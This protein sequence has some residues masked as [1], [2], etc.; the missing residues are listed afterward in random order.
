MAI[1]VILGEDN[2]LVRE[3]LRQ[4]LAGAP[5]LD[6]EAECGDGDELLREVEE[7]RPDVV[8]TD[9]RMPPTHTDEGIRLAAH[10]R[11]AHPHIGVVVLSQYAD[12]GYVL[13]LLESG[14]EGRAYLLKERVHDRR[15]LVAAIEAVASGESVID[16]K[17]VEVLVA[18]K[19]RGERS[20]LAQLTP[21]ELE[22]LAAIAEG[23]SNGAISE[24]LVLTKRAVEKHIN[25]IFL[26][27]N[28][29]QSQSAETVSPRV[30]A[31]LVFLAETSDPLG[32]GKRAP[33]R[34]RGRAPLSPSGVA[35][36]S[37]GAVCIRVL[38]VDDQAVFR[39]IAREVIDATPGFEA[40]G[41][42]AS[43]EEAL[44]A[45]ARLAPQLVL[46]DVR[47]PGL[48]G[49]EVARRLRVTHPDTVLV[50][51]SIEDWL[52]HPSAAQIAERV[53]LV[54]KQD[55]GPRHAGVDLARARSRCSIH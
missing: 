30:K 32:W 12:P 26:K 15:Q 50:L 46:L 24:A 11:V 3:G 16:P 18:A 40:V 43:G 14:S 7:R 1:R 48:D 34:I 10:L 2:Y 55:F 37:R 52:D 13:E 21:R 51:I 47:M 27:L 49:I 42:A 53:P 6:V 54:R 36:Y 5:H 19:S 9:I 29:S 25:A 17:I 31:A 20:P 38:T 41:E 23:K 22:V 8:L 45:V 4:V 39:G 44:E 28:L 35:T 33:P